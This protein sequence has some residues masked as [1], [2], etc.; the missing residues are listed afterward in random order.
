[1]VLSVLEQKG[2]H[3]L[4]PSRM[5]KHHI[6]LLEQDDVK[7]KT[8]T[9]INPAIFLSSI[10]EEVLRHDCLQTIKQVYYSR[11]NRRV[12]IPDPEF[13]ICTYGS[14][15]VRNGRRLAGYAITITNS[16]I[17]A[18]PLSVNTSAQKAEL[19]TSPHKSPKM[20]R[21]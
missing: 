11:S 16:V 8:T 21:T 18:K 2:G 9:T 10:E 7:S 4:S 6:V 17:D 1:M 14:S 3:W 12:N 15:I 5:L 13:E 19:I 20:D